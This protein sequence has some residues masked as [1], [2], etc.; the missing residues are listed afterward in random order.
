[1]HVQMLAAPDPDA[2]PPPEPDMEVLGPLIDRAV[3]GPTLPDYEGVPDS[4]SST[5]GITRSVFSS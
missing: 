1:M 4:R 3:N 2:G 5:T